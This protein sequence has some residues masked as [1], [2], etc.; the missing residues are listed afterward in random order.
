MA[1]SSK[2]SP[3][4]RVVT[5]KARAELRARAGKCHEQAELLGAGYSARIEIAIAQGLE[6]VAESSPKDVDEDSIL[7]RI[8]EGVSKS[9]L[10]LT[11]QRI[12]M[13]RI[14]ELVGGIRSSERIRLRRPAPGYG[15]PRLPQRT[16]A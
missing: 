3:T 4:L 13:R 7:K 8:I 2:E 12:A 16:P 5:E 14:R 10:T 1:N 11:E 9:R 15:Y 6:M